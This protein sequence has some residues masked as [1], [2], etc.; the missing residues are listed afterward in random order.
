MTNEQKTIRNWQGR[1]NEIQIPKNM[2]S[3]LVLDFL[4]VEGYR[5]AAKKFEKEAGIDS[6]HPYFKDNKFDDGNE[7]LMEQRIQVRR[8]I[9]DGQIKNAIDLINEINPGVSLCENSNHFLLLQIL[10][11]NPDLNF[12]LRK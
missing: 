1:L 5:E 9:L 2:M 8:F 3:M 10:D 7:E 11:H 4:R 12:E 6:N